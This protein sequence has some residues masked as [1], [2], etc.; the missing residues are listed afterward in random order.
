MGRRRVSGFRCAR[1]AAPTVRQLRLDV[2]DA[3]TDRAPPAKLSVSSP[4]K[5]PLA[6]T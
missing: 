3:E 2:F 4:K 6:R 5:R 1:Q